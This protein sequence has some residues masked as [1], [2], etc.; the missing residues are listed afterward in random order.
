MTDIVLFGE[1]APKYLI[2]SN[3]QYGSNVKKNIKE[4]VK[5]DTIPEGFISVFEYAEY[6]HLSP[7]SVRR[8]CLSGGIVG[9]KKYMGHW[10]IPQGYKLERTK[11]I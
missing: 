8:Y 5:K 1:N 4:E 11:I 10:V 3:Q 7:N 6:K 9:A 2:I